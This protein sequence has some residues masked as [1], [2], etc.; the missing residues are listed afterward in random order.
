MKNPRF[1]RI[2]CGG[3]FLA[4]IWSAISHF[5]VFAEDG[6]PP[7]DPV[8]TQSAGAQSPVPEIDPQ[9]VAQPTATLEEIAVGLPVE[10]LTAATS[11]IPSDPPPT[12]VTPSVEIV[13]LDEAGDAL[14]L[15]A[16]AAAEILAT[17]DPIWCPASVTVPRPNT[18]GCT[19]S[20]TSL[21]LLFDELELN[22]KAVDG[23]I[24]IEKDY[25]DTTAATLDGSLIAFERM[26]DFR[27]TLKGGWNGCG[28]NPPATCT[29]TI[30][31]LSPSEINH[32][33]EIL[34]WNND[35]T[36][37]DVLITG[38]TGTDP[39]LA[40]ETTG[41]VTLN[42]VEVSR[43]DGPGADLDNTGGARDISITSGRF[44]SN[45]GG[46]GLNVTSNGTVTLSGVTA[47][48][49]GGDGLSIK[50]DISSTP[51][52]V[53]LASGNFEFAGNS[54]S[55][56]VILS[57]GLITIKDIA[58]MSN[59][60]DG[61][62]LI[63][64]ASPIG[65]GITLLGTNIF[66]ENLGS[67]LVIASSGLISASNL[68][69][70][71][72]M[73]FGAEIDN[74]TATKSNG[75]TLS[76][77][78]EFKF[79]GTGLQ[80][81]SNG[82]ITLNNI[83]AT[84]NG[85]SFGASLDN[86]NSRSASPVTLNGI[87]NFNLNTQDGL[88]VSSTGVITINKTTASGNGIGGTAGYGA[89]L[90][91]AA[92]LA[93]GVTLVGAGVFSD[94]LQDGLYLNTCGSV[95]ISSLTTQ[96]NEGNGANI[97]NLAADKTP[98]NVTLTGPIITSGNGQSGLLI[99]SLGLISVANV[100]ANENGQAGA[101]LS[102]EDSPT[103]KSVT[104]S[105]ASSFFENGGNGLTVTS[106]G[107]ITLNNVRANQNKGLGASILNNGIS[108]VGA[109]TINGTN[110]FSQNAS[111]GLK[112]SSLG[113]IQVANL[114]A[115]GNGGDGVSLENQKSVVQGSISLGTSL[116]NWCNQLSDNAIS[117]LLI[118]SN[119]AVTLSNIC[120][121][122]NGS[123]VSPGFGASIDNHTAALP[124]P[125]K[126]AGVNSFNDNYSGGIELLTRG[127]ITAS[128][129]SAT[130]NLH[131][132]GAT[133]D[134][135]FST[136][137]SPQPVALSG[138][139]KFSANFGDGLTVTSFG[140]I[141]VNN[142]SASSNGANGGSGY[143]AWLDNC[144]WQIDHCTT[145]IPQTVKLTGANS[146][147]SN[148]GD[149]LNVISLGAISANNLSANFNAGSGAILNN[150]IAGATGGIALSGTGNS[151]NE[152][153]V[154]GL[155]A[156]SRR[157]ISIA[158]LEASS[159]FG[160]GASLSNHLN[161]PSPQNIAVNG[162]ALLEGNIGFGLSVRTLG[163][164]TISNLNAS[165][166]GAQGAIL[167]NAEA[168]ATGAVTLSGIQIL[169]DNASSGLEIVSNRAV[170]LSNLNAASNGGYGVSIDNRL[171]GLSNNVAILG[172]NAFNGNDLT[173]LDIRTYGSIILNYITATNNGLDEIPDF[174]HGV[175][176]DNRTAA[177]PVKAITLTGINVFSG[178]F[179]DGLHALSLGQITLNSLTANRN[180][181]SGANLDNHDGPISAGIS[182]NGMNHFSE[183]GNFGLSAKSAG[184]ITLANSCAEW[185]SGG[186]ARIDNSGASAAANVTLTGSNVFSHNG[187]TVLDSGSGLLIDST[188]RITL[189]NVTADDN[190][191]HGVFLNNK[192]HAVGNFAI[193]LTG[194]NTFSGNNNM[195]LQIRA[196][197]DI[198][199]AKVTADG[200]VG[201]GVHIVGARNVSLSCA[202]LTRNEGT[203]LYIFA[204]FGKVTLKGVFAYGNEFANTG[205]FAP[206]TTI[207]R[208]CS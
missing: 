174:G 10:E 75:V 161:S 11:E 6:D 7:P 33:L 125:V 181:G 101:S 86:S 120:A 158:N 186:G 129:L 184:S 171:F 24:W 204:E 102:N 104:V 192:D 127:P 108:A 145:V 116:A 151:F 64:T 37:S 9:A 208:G 5:S 156:I 67:G 47:S 38:A 3:L 135:T 66:S 195:G 57:N 93:K 152:N 106:K 2:L 1:L 150:D 87:N 144:N 131:G 128:N 74:T 43:N 42:R 4:L 124:N 190:S 97:L 147:S 77:A 143:G 73:D 117:G 12:E 23:V 99:S 167:D 206:N 91:N 8:P 157:A 52:N 50:N 207:I 196:A 154:N 84:K 22:P 107:L 176:L 148:V 96:G 59:G 197:G 60:A 53:S 202:S 134:N 55:G 100:T 141:T 194:V 175:Y 111:H 138:Y 121:T 45:A 203:G 153:K 191:S 188:G 14:P 168:G 80:I 29:G 160:F 48:A 25:S 83:T 185:N 17:G 130:N 56:I 198:S 205:G 49:N 51:K 170:S 172:V 54:G 126:L 71:A 72:N 165:G 173:G 115:I 78:S 182:L 159:N 95:S 35:V 40:I 94:N 65:Q 30:D 149:G 113:N 201:E 183:N 79:N 110:E 177:S 114:K 32:Q 146:F 34:H 44:D 187:T 189:S 20:F 132:F 16:D 41:K 123:F 92:G 62:R 112:A 200:N 19:Q 155:E 58:S 180:G 169:Y 178:N 26:R 90:D 21:D 133:L 136:V 70:N 76:G 199:L 89:W 179:E 18:S 81:L 63:N 139:N 36:L 82:A 85:N 98:Q 164:I 31:T 109:I 15:A 61:A 13:I 119:G 28:T 68:I 103:P 140:A 193:T 27:L 163:A 46:D 142:L 137:S 88:K 69:N 39:A 166:N 122:A 162:F 118:A 105:G